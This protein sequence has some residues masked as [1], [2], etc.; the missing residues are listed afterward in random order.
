MSLASVAPALSVATPLAEARAKV[1]PP[2]AFDLASMFLRGRVLE[3]SGNLNFLP[4][5]ARCRLA[6]AS[7]HACALAMGFAQQLLIATKRSVTLMPER[8]GRLEMMPWAAS[9][10]GAGRIG[11]ALM[12]KGVA[13]PVL[14]KR[15]LSG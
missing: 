4:W 6:R 13:N 9:A 8:L 1:T 2:R 12:P 3:L 11:A 5:S 10:R 7:H 14:S 15:A